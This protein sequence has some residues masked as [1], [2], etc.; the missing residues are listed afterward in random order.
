[1]KCSMMKETYVKRIWK[2][3][4]GEFF[5]TGKS[6]LLMDSA[7]SHLGNEVEH[8]FTDVNS[9][10]MIIHGGMTPLLQFLDT[11]VK[12]P[13]KDIMKEKWEDRIVNGEAELTKKGNRKRASYQL[14]AEWADDTWK[15]VATDELIIKRFCQ[16]GYIEYDGET[17][18]LHSRLQ[19]TIKKREVPDEVIQGVNEFLEEMMALQLDEES[20]D[21]EVELCENCTANVNE[22]DDGQ[23]DEDNYSEEND[24]VETDD[25]EINAVDL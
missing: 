6:I 14:A 15:K 12:K 22:N 20:P 1:M 10:I 4:P 18:N 17:S 19:E 25:D 7:K 16:C 3:R 2:R 13:F 11:Y 8:A 24:G 23:S 5:N 9:S 21:E